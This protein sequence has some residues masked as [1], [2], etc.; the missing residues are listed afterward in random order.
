MGFGVDSL[1]HML[2]KQQ[3]TATALGVGILGLILALLLEADIGLTSGIWYPIIY[4]GAPAIAATA[5]FAHERP[6][7]GPALLLGIG[8][9]ILGSSILALASAVVLS[10]G[11]PAKF[12]Q[13]PVSA[14]LSAGLL[15]LGFLLVPVL[16]T[17]VAARRRCLQT[18]L[19]LV[20]VPVG[21]ALLAGVLIVGR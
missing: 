18:V 6:N 17:G 21:Q 13:S 9:W 14:V 12:T 2:T 1:E 8:V 19:A 3:S 16:L 10:L 20:F 15:F 5:T 11:T 7:V 4:A